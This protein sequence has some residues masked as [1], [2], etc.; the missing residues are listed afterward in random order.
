MRSPT[1][2]MPLMPGPSRV[3][4]RAYAAGM[5]DGLLG[6]LSARACPVCGSTD[7]SD[8][9]A[10]QRLDSASLDRYA[11]ASRKRPEHMRLRLV[12]CPQCDL[13]YASHV[14]A[15]EA[16]ARAYGEAA[17][18]SAIEARFAARTYREALVGLLRTLPDRDG[19]LDIGTGEGAFL[20]ELL[21]A[22][23]TAVG[24][25]EPSAEPID[26]AEPRIAELI[27]HDVFRPDLRPPGSLSLVT[28][29]QTIEHVPD[30]TVLVREAAQMLKPG[31][32]LALV[33]HDRRAP[34]NRLLG[35]RSPI[36][37]I[38]HQQLFS[39]ASVSR[40]LRAAGLVDVG[41]RAIR[42][43][44]PLRYWI[45]LLPLPRQ[46]GELA[47]RLLERAGLGDRA[48]TVPVGNLLAWGRRPADPERT[49]AR[50]PAV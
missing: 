49:A 22:G 25:V 3:A 27:E 37:D 15:P 46:G 16:L 30:P 8:V 19:A 13:V 33:C 21:D 43:R 20:R 38:E 11:F 12:S 1:S 50:A 26:A 5:A 6:E 39:P 14:P 35:L 28:C 41:H 45:R 24:G 23:F 2:T 7:D 10:A 40:L 17:F 32:V 47:E 44:Y 48:L 34:I 31:G 36:V 42:N 18:D 29:F 4:D 9:F